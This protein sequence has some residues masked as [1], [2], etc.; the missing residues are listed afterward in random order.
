[1][2]YSQIGSKVQQ[3][4]RIHC[5]QVT[6]GSGKLPRADRVLTMHVSFAPQLRDQGKQ[7][8]VGFT[9]QGNLMH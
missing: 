6:Q 5:E 9:P 1:M 4:P 7:P 2:Y 3:K 8:T